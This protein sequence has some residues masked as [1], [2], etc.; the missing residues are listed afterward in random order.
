M[1]AVAEVALV[2]RV[3]EKVVGAREVEA[4]VVVRVEVVRAVVAMAAETGV[5]GSAVAVKEAEATEAAGKEEATAV[6]G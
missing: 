3:E 4:M 1:T 2:A 5:G 6:G